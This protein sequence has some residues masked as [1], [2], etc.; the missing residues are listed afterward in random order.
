MGSEFYIAENCFPT[1][2]PGTSV[3]GGIKNIY[4]YNKGPK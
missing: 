2:P 1:D 4:K 3:E